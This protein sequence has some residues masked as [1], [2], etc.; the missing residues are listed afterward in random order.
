M[1]LYVRLQ[2]PV[3]LEVLYALVI[4]RVTI[5]RSSISHALQAP[6]PALGKWSEESA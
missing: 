3:D 6:L 2:L 4:A 5:H 1:A